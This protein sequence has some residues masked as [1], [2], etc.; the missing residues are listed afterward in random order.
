MRKVLIPTDFSENAMNAIRYALELFK[1]ERS[2]FIIFHAYADEVYENTLEMSRELFEA[3]RE[4]VQEKSDTELQHV[5]AQMLAISPNPRHT[6][7]SLSVFGSLVDVS[8]DLV[9][10]ENADVLVMGTRGATDQRDITFGSNT[11]Q[12]IKYVKC[13]VL[14]IPSRFHDV[15]PKNILYTTDYLLPCQRREIKMLST[16]ARKFVATLHF[17]YITAFD[18]LSYR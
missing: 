3:Y 16:L 7:H 14:A 13:P 9:D 2:E 8:N 17:L 1:Y 15:H 18:N 4:K 12:V 10:K 6:Y 5:L 11:L